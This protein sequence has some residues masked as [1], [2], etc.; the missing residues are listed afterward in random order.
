[1]EHFYGEKNDSWH[2]LPVSLSQKKNQP[3]LAFHG[4]L[5][6]VSL[7][8]IF[9]CWLLYQ[10]VRSWK[11]MFSFSHSRHESVHFSGKLQNTISI[12]L[13]QSE[14]SQ[15]LAHTTSIYILVF[16]TSPHETK[17]MTRNSPIDLISPSGFSPIQLLCLLRRLRSKSNFGFWWERETLGKASQSRVE[18]QQIQLTDT[19]EVRIDP[20]SY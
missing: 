18:S 8:P 11:L 14:F 9:S 1:M 16:Y 4:S 3:L 15:S 17:H 2:I 6:K 13:S 10:N 19:V 20:G 5:S 12:Q 7:F